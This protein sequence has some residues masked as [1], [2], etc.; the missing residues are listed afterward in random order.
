MAK[1]T[2][3]LKGKKTYII[4]MLIGLDA[5]A[6]AMGYTVPGYIYAI[7]GAL[8]LGFTRAAITKVS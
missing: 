5:A 8:G 3:W 2:E 1:F 7:L 4:A 6:Q